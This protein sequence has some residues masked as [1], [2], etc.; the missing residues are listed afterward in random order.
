MQSITLTCPRP[1]KPDSIL[2]LIFDNL[3]EGNFN[4]S[5]FEIIGNTEPSFEGYG[6][7]TFTL[8]NKEKKFSEEIIKNIKNMILQCMIE[9]VIIEAKLDDVVVSYNCS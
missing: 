1:I 9:L 8:F 3:N 2:Q 6:K 7:W 5:D 4:L